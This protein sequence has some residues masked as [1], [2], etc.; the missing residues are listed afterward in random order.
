MMDGKPQKYFTVV[1]EGDMRTIAGNPF[2]V[3]SIWGKPVVIA[4]GD[5]TEERDRLEERLDL[6]R[7]NYGET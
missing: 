2:N 4:W 7:Q 1:F 6:Y 5:V 3:E